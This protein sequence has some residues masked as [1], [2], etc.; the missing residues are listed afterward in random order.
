M[1]LPL[2][3]IF[4]PHQDIL[5]TIEFIWLIHQVSNFLHFILEIHTPPPPRP[6]PKEKCTNKSHVA[7]RERKTSEKTI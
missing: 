6:P 3:V 7:P 2:L 1:N 4:F 5:G